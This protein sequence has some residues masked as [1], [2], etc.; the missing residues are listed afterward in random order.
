MLTCLRKSLSEGR[1]NL[2][3][4]KWDVLLGILFS[5]A[6]LAASVF[7]NAAESWNAKYE[8]VAMPEIHWQVTSQQSRSE[9]ALDESIC[10]MTKCNASLLLYYFTLSRMRYFLRFYVLLNYV[11]GLGFNSKV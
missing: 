10:K 8:C 7:Q 3:M 6:A 11:A 5:E 9:N 2:K 4:N 1:K